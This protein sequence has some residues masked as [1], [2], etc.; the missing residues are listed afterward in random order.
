MTSDICIIGGGAAG[1]WTRARLAA[2]GF[3]VVLIDRGGLGDGQTVLSQGILHAGLKYAMSATAR[4][5]A[6]HAAD[7]QWAWNGALGGRGVPDLSRVPVIARALHMW[8]TPGL[9]SKATAAGAAAV[10]KS[11][12][13]RLDGDELPAAFRGMP[14]GFAVWEIGERA[15]DPEALV[16]ELADGSLGPL[17]TDVHNITLEHDGGRVV[18]AACGAA[19][20]EARAFVFAAGVGNE[21]YLRV[22]GADVAEVS[23][24]RALHMLYAAAAPFEMFAHCIRPGSDKPRLSITTSRV[25][26]AAD[27]LVWY[28]GGDI[29]ETGVAR[30]EA[31]QIA[32]A[33]SEFAQ[34]LPWIDVSKLEWRTVRVDRAEGKV[35]GGGRPDGPVVHVRGNAVF[36]W[37]TKLVMAP[38]AAEMVEHELSLIDVAPS[39]P[40]PSRKGEEWWSVVGG[41]RISVAEPP[42]ARSAPIAAVGSSARLPQR[43]LGRAGM[44]V[45]MLGLGT[46]KLG[47]T[48]G[49]KYPT[50]F[51]LP[52]DEEAARLLD[53]AS[54]LGITLLD[55]AP[56]YGVAEE[57]LG[58][59][60][61]GR[62]E[63]FTLFTKAG[64]EFEGGVSGVSGV[65]GIS[66]VSRYDFTP[67]GIERSVERSLKRLRVDAVDGV[68]LHSDGVAEMRFAEMGS[69]DALERLKTRGLVRAIGA[70]TK[71]LEGAMAAIPRSDVIMVTLNEEDHAAAGAVAAAR[72]KGV[73]VI[74]KKAL[75]SGYAAAGGSAQESLRAAFKFV[76]DVP[77]V[78]SAVVGTINPAHL[79]E[80]V[81][82]VGG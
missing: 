77:G 4:G 15:V 76:F 40:G 36:L 49:V 56:A 13:R 16:R 68:L 82:A 33:R 28:V 37:P 79:R 47:R 9:L 18:A 14:S 72:A 81:W 19:R 38:A 41:A 50:P 80:N 11:A 26:G 20:V 58:V 45:S 66:G 5:A 53:L 12:A 1:L 78:S 7:A 32:F 52:T 31:E 61:R 71:T 75:R 60:L 51:E 27:R 24:L 29:A 59:L 57:R 22:L 17:F 64:E 73:G 55:T 10:L 70:S 44:F 3:R 8:A 46:V 2:A 23:Q 25:G 39:D 34:C 74:V 35:A 43:A 69:F 48:S 62:R 63:R 67:E 6:R 54:E 65:S 30:S 21:Q 42:W